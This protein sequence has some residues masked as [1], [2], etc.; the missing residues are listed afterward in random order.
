M[1]TCILAFFCAFSISQLSAQDKKEVKKVVVIEKVT[2]ENGKVVEKKVVKEG[3]EAEAYMNKMEW[4]SDEGAEIKIRVQSDSSKIVEKKAFKFISKD[5]EGN[6]R[7]FEWSGDGEMPEE[8]K[9][10]LE[11]NDIDIDMD[12]EFNEKF[13]GEAIE[14][15][16][17]IDEENVKHINVI[18]TDG[19]EKRIEIILEGDEIP[20]D[21]QE[22]L[23]EENIFIMMDE[24][25]EGEVE[26]IVR[27]ESNDSH[28][29]KAQLGVLIEAAENGVGVRDVMEGTAAEEVGIQ[30]GDIIQKINDVP[31]KSIEELLSALKPFKPGDNVVVE[32]LRNGENIFFEATL[33]SRNPEFDK[34][35]W[36]SA[37]E[38]EEIHEIHEEHKDGHKVI[39]KKV[40]IKKDDK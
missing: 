25:E 22:M 10:L 32:G 9:E 33:K 4:H 11:E 27:T 17:V 8:M 19:D 36:K 38:G 40:I 20:A 5:E 14:I 7:V 3:A 34:T 35:S 13:E 12:I 16:E 15:D 6:E 29:N 24:G 28:S 26:V 31:V 23:E 1:T 2:D 30:K 37:V 21:V 18:K 39:K